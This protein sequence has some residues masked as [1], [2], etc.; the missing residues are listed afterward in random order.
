MMSK[1]TAIFRLPKKVKKSSA[2]MRRVKRNSS[3]M[4][5]KKRSVMEVARKIKK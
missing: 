4:R 1:R 2:K 3:K 5:R